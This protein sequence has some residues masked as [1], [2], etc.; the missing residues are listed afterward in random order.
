MGFKKKMAAAPL[1]RPN[2]INNINPKMMAIG[3]GFEPPQGLFYNNRL[4]IS[5]NTRLCSLIIISYS[6]SFGI[7]KTSLIVQK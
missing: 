5:K 3:E 1:P 6:I 7:S 4:T 2:S